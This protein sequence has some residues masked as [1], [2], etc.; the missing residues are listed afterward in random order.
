MCPTG[1]CLGGFTWVGEKTVRNGTSMALALLLLL[2]IGA[3][4]IQ[5][6]VSG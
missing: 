6:T 5:L 2:I 3:A 1:R 4:V